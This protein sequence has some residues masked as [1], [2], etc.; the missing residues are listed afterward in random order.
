MKWKE[1]TIILELRPAKDDMGKVIGKRAELL[2]Q[3]E[4]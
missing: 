3:L 1:R 4:Q 2:K